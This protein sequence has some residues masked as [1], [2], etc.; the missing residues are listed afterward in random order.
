MR[1]FL[2]ILCAVLA[3][4]PD[5]AHA[6]TSKVRITKNPDMQSYQMDAGGCWVVR[7]YLT[8]G[9]V[10]VHAANALSPALR[11]I[12]G[13]DSIGAGTGAR[14]LT[15]P[16]AFS[17]SLHLGGV[18][19]NLQILVYAAI[20]SQIKAGNIIITGTDLIGAAL[21]DTVA[22]TEDT[23][24]RTQLGKCFYTV[25]NITFPA[26]DNVAVRFYVGRG[27]AFGLPATTA[28]LMRW[29]KNGLIQAAVI[30]DSCGVHPLQI[31]KN[32][33]KTKWQAGTGNIDAL[34]FV[35]PYTGWTGTNPW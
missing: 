12:T 16:A 10:S 29:Y 22:I 4:T 3:F 32:F 30:P 21:K 25:S 2:L 33:W 6:S 20:A 18:A 14:S 31:A 23:A 19:R 27:Y 24:L 7:R 8:P 13:K 5:L 1:R 9:V 17:D 28:S 34:I 26:Q 11:V 15:P 35:S